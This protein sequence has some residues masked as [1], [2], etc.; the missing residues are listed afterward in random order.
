MRV[1]GVVC[2]EFIA[3]GRIWLLTFFTSPSPSPSS[4]SLSVRAAGSGSWHVALCLIEHNRPTFVNGRL[5][6][7]SWRQI[8]QHWTEGDPARGLH[9]PLRDWPADWMRG[10][11]KALFA[12]K[13]KQRA[14]ITLECLERFGGNEAG[15]W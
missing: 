3:R 1:A 4:S 10:K 14:V 5:R 2:V 6:K 7:D 11:N 12:S 13:Y 8:I 9:L 15:S